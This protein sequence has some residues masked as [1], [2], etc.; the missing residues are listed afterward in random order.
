[1]TMVRERSTRLTVV[2]AVAM[3]IVVISAMARPLPGGAQV[4]G[5]GWIGDRV[6]QDLNGNGIQDLGEPGV[7]G[8]RITVTSAAGSAVG[9]GTSDENG[10]Y[11]ITGPRVSRQSPVRQSPVRQLPLR[12][13]LL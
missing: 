11:R 4:A 10:A 3:L 2:G 6:W 1:M 5:A 13:S 9:S 7:A 12:Q 8:V